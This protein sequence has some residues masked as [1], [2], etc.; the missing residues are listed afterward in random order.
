MKTINKIIFLL[1]C[2]LPFISE[3]THAFYYDGRPSG[4]LTGATIGGL[5]GGGKGAA[6]GLGVGATAD[7]IGSAA[8][9]ADRRRYYDDRRYPYY[10]RGYY[11]EGYATK[12]PRNK[13][14]Y[15]E[16]ERRNAELESQLQAPIE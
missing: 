6:I 14:S 3:L 5:A 13:L 7:I 8:A 12:Y 10:D 2:C 15:R 4:A 9:D 11:R 1:F 16:L